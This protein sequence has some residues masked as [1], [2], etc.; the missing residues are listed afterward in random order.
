[1]Q[2]MVAQPMFA[3]HLNI[4]DVGGMGS[5]AMINGLLYRC[6]SG[7]FHAGI[8]VHG[9]EFYFSSS[10]SPEPLLAGSGL[11]RCPPKACPEHFFRMTVP[12]SP[13]RLSPA[14]VQS[15]LMSLSKTWRA[16]G[17]D[18]YRRNCCHFAA[19]FAKAL[20]AGDVEAW[21]THLAS[22]GA[23]LEDAKNTALQT[24]ENIAATAASLAQNTVMRVQEFGEM[25]KVWVNVRESES[26]SP[27]RSVS[28]VLKKIKQNRG[29][30]HAKGTKGNAGNKCATGRKKRV[31]CV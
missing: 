10:A 13:T 5:A 8:E 6:G 25:A 7:A 15:C 11:W 18:L 22:V 27:S 16:E 4:Y 19:E 3:V 29:N 30:K 26:R 21:V 28:P 2:G 31:V 12:M 9:L 23:S 20:G 1:M 17:Y 24:C 14:Q